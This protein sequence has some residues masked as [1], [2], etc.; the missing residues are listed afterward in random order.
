MNSQELWAVFFGYLTNKEKRSK[1][2]GIIEIEEGIA[3]AS[4]VL[5]GYTQEEKEYFWAIS[6]EKYELDMQ[7]MLVHAEREG[8]KHGVE[9]TARNA[10]A[11]GA[12]IEFVHKIT[13]LDIE[14]IKSLQTE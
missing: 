12:S 8:L 9:K 3:M 6:R 4:E 2:N 1:I 13:G 11:E 7:S 14:K 5:M 10:L